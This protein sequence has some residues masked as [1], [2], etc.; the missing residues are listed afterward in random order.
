MDHLEAQ[1]LLS[2]A[3]DGAQVDESALA[4]ARAHAAECAECGAF[5]NGIQLIAAVPGS[6]APDGLVDGIL[7]R[8]QTEPSPVPVPAPEPREKRR[9]WLAPAIVVGVSFA[10]LAI[11]GIVSIAALT[12]EDAGSNGG[13]AV[14]MEG[15]ATA[16]STGDAATA[17]RAEEEAAADAPD[18]AGDWVSFEG[19]VYDVQ[20]TQSVD[21][22]DLET[23]GVTATAM[24]SPTAAPSEYLV[25]APVEEDVRGLYL[26]TETSGTYYRLD[27]VGRFYDGATYH[28]ATGTTLERFGEWPTLPRSFTPPAAEDGAPT[29]TA[30]DDAGGVTV[31]VAIG[32]TPDYGIAIAPGSPA[33]DPARGNPGWSWWDPFE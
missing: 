22:S 16:P 30:W 5:E 28:L 13:E 6:V 33:T 7:A 18:A 25:F 14:D 12:G 24:E 4:E 26:S 3:Q 2:E 19:L 23:V 1:Q 21:A 20:G 17:E 15:L 9:T 32:R 29:F 11:V 10:A 8:V 31:Y 27:P